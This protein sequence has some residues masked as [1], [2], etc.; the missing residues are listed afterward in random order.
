MA[1]SIDARRLISGIRFFLVRHKQAFLHLKVQHVPSHFGLDGLQYYAIFPFRLTMI[2]RPRNVVPDLA[3]YVVRKDWIAV[4]SFEFTQGP[5]HQIEGQCAL[6]A[7][8]LAETLLQILKVVFGRH[9]FPLVG[10]P[11]K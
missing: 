6:R 10:G 4:E 5:A 2:E 1:Q 8:D 7:I 9:D 11:L 3:K